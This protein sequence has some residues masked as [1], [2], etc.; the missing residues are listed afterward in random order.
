MIDGCVIIVN[1]PILFVE[2]SLLEQLEQA[3]GERREAELRRED[4]VKRVKQLQNK[5]QNKRNQGEELLHNS[6]CC[7]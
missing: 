3:R 7:V 1:C 5:A 4:L 6:N 2:E